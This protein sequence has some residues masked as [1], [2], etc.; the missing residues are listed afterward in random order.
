MSKIRIEYPDGRVYD[1]NG[2]LIAEYPNY[3]QKE[4]IK[5]KLTGPAG[6]P[7]VHENKIGDSENWK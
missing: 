1:E 3:E 6:F 7:K 2:K 5:R 4:W